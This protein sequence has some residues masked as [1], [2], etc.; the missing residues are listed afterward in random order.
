MNIMLQTPGERGALA[1]YAMLNNCMDIAA[2][3]VCSGMP[4]TI[5]GATDAQI[6]AARLE[7]AAIYASPMEAGEMAMIAAVLRACKWGAPKRRP[8]ARCGG[9]GTIEDDNSE[10]TCA[11]CG[12]SGDAEHY[13]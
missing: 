10:A 11:P 12:G 1:T 9:T 4:Y 5:T 7:A 2:S 6:W 8:C 3:L 13:L